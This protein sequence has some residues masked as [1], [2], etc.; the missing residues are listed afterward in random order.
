MTKEFFYFKYTPYAARRPVKKNK[1]ELMHSAEQ[2]A[3]KTASRKYAARRPV[4]K[5]CIFR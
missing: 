5:I 4:K 3:E 2:A 1:L